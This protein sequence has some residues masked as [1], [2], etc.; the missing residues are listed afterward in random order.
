[1]SKLEKEINK[2]LGEEIEKQSKKI[3][4]SSYA[5]GAF[6]GMCFIKDRINSFFGEINQKGQAKCENW[7]NFYSHVI[8]FD[9]RLAEKELT[10]EFSKEDLL[11]ME[12]F[13]AN[14]LEICQ[15]VLKE[16]YNEQSENAI[17]RDKLW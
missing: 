2:L 4:S 14:S 17:Q 13:L 9:Y 1:M 6:S 15:K 3:H 8:G 5:E 16:K 12:M 7:E 11:E 10:E